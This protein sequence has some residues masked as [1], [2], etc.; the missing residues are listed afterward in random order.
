MGVKLVAG[1]HVPSGFEMVIIENQMR[2]W[3][4]WWNTMLTD[5][6]EAWDDEIRL[7]NQMQSKLGDLTE[8]HR[9]IRAQ[10]AEFCRYN[11]LF[12]QSVDILCTEIGESQFQVPVKM[13]CEG[14]GLLD[15]MIHRDSDA[16][17]KETLDQY[18]AALSK[19]PCQTGPGTLM[20]SKVSGFLGRETS[21]KRENVGRLLSVTSNGGT[22]A[23]SLA[24]QSPSTPRLSA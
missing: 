9:L 19:W 12:P 2:A 21:M 1:R 15:S 20:E 4:L 17:W 24:A 16:A 23:L 13:G 6:P 3:N 5:D 10:I 14:R 7:I 18:N 11:P 22:L 8:Q